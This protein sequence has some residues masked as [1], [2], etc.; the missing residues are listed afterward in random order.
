MT[1]SEGNLVLTLD[2]EP[3]YV[4]GER[5][6]AC[7]IAG[8]LRRH[9]PRAKLLVLGLNKAGKDPT[10]GTLVAALE[11]L[12]ALAAA[13]AS[14]AARAKAAITASMTAGVRTPLR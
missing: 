1:A 6:R 13:C 7:L 10:P 4:T 14:A 2:G 3:A 8:W 12:G 5:Q 9:K 11:G